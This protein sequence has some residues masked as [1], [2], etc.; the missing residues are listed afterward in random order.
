MSEDQHPDLFGEAGHVALRDSQQ[1]FYVAA[2]LTTAYLR[3]RSTVKQRQALQSERER[4]AAEA[5][6]KAERDAIR[7][8]WEPAHDRQW[9]RSAGPVDVAEAWSAAAP[10]ADP[11]A[12]LY[13]RSAELAADNCEARLRDLHPYAMN[14]YDRLR[15]DGL[16]RVEAMHEAVPLFLNH[17][18]PRPHGPGSRPGLAVGGLGDPWVAEVHGPGREEFEQHLA[19]QQAARGARIVEG[20][21]ARAMAEDRPMLDPDE[22]HTALEAATNLPPEIIA[23]IVPAASP[24]PA[25]RPWENESPFSIEEV[26]AL[27]AHQPEAPARPAPRPDAG[28]RPG[29]AP[30]A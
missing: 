15:G 29:R 18:N 20:M 21:Q 11:A 25:R 30:H 2:A 3:H 28:R 5:R 19:G 16:G 13:E 8:R 4:R 10:Y 26:V 24:R 27:A 7:A 17:P 23:K 1:A 9:L 6:E 14:H 12:D 22:Q